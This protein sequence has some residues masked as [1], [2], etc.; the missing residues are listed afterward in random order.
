MSGLDELQDR[1]QGFEMKGKIEVSPEAAANLKVN[2]D[3]S[4]VVHS[5]YGTIKR[6]IRLKKGLQASHIFIPAG[7]NNND[8]M[9]LFGLSDMTNP[10]S[11]GWKTCRVRVEKA[12]GKN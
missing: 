10:D 5:K 1:I 6:K 12:Q 3:D 9:Q 4:I 11:S 8:A 7:F 2:D